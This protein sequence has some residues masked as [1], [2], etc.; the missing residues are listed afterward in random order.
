MSN[1]IE[2]FDVE[3]PKQTNRIL[4]NINGFELTNE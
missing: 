2:L 1:I 4:E 3:K